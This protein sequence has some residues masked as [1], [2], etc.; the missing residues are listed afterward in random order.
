MKRLAELR[1]S[2]AL[3][4]RDLAE[5]SGVD[6]N[7]INQVELGHRRAR[8]S[9]IRKLARGLG[10]DPEELTRPLAPAR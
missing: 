9:T 4:L 5:L 10:V 1:E 6:A 3:T 2:Q 7:T 8:P